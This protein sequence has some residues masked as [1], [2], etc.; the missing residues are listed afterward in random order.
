M[1]LKITYDEAKLLVNALNS[2]VILIEY[3]EDLDPADSLPYRDLYKKVVYLINR[4]E[5]N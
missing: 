5:V 1:N 3:L 4:E 2:K